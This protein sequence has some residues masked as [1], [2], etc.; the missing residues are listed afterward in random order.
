MEYFCWFGRKKIKWNYKRSLRS[1]SRS[2]L[3]SKFYSSKLINMVRI[4]FILLLGLVFTL[5][6]SLPLNLVG[7]ENQLE[8]GKIKVSLK[9][10]CNWFFLHEKQIPNMEAT[11][12]AIW[13]WT[14]INWMNWLRQTETDW[15]SQ[16]IDGQTK[17][18]H[19]NWIQ[20]TRKN[21]KLTLN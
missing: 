15:F 6:V 12:K 8:E 18:F 11:M 5:T 13:F 19:I 17:P 2:H 7:N 3:Q 1:L 4:S 9:I 16:N 14:K 21:N 10:V 20:I